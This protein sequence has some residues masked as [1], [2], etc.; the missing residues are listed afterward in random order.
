MCNGSILTFD[1]FLLGVKVEVHMRKDIT[2][3]APLKMGAYQPC[4][5]KI[6]SLGRMPFSAGEKL[7]C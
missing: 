1:P 7:S 5:T 2:A 6:H 4:N 3:H